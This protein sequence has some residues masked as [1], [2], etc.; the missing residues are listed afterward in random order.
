MLEVEN[1]ISFI[2]SSN[3]IADGKKM[4]ELQRLSD[5][6]DTQAEQFK[7]TMWSAEVFVNMLLTGEKKNEKEISE[8]E[9]NLEK[10]TIKN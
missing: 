1:V 6:K 2:S 10:L 5:K 4:S 7:I 3:N 9:G 8:C